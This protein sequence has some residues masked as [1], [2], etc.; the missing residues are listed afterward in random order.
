MKP[1]EDNSTAAEKLDVKIWE[2]SY[3]RSLPG[4]ALRS[5]DSVI[6]PTDLKTGI[7]SDLEWFLKNE[8]WYKDRGIPYHRGYL[9]TGPPGTG[10][11]S[12]V[13]ALATHLKKT[14][15][16]LNMSSVSSDNNLQGAFWAVRKGSIMLM[17]DLDA[18][19]Q[20][21]ITEDKDKDKKDTGQISLSGL[22]NAIDGITSPD[23]L[24]LI[25]T[26]NQPDKLDPAL[27]RP[28]RVD[29]CVA[30]EHLNND[31]CNVMFSRFYPGLDLRIPQTITDIQPSK[32]Q[33]LFMEHPAN[34][35]A[36]LE[37]LTQLVKE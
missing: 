21:R 37:S 3:W 35:H 9:F 26:T 11:T 28:G 23:G 13:Q 20:S 30:F 14:V 29:K 5:L 15:Y 10:K 27:L 2:H 4:R 12:L 36:A 34:G 18:V 33:S 1:P 16:S 7:V 6:L 32:L 24:V 8:D 22:L 25:M 19:Q 31:L 17:E